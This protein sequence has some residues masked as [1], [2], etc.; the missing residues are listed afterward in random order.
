MTKQISP[1]RGMAV[2]IEGTSEGIA[3]KV[4]TTSSG[5]LG[6]ELVRP[7]Q[8]PFQVGDAVR[9]VYWEKGP[10]VCRWNG[11]II[12]VG[13]PQ[14]RHLILS[15]LDQ[16]VE[17]RTFPRFEAAIPFTFTVVDSANATL[18]G[19]SAA[20]ETQNIGVGGLLFDARH[21]L[22]VGDKLALTLKLSASQQADTLGWVVRSTKVK[23]TQYV[24]GTMVKLVHSVAVEFLQWKRDSQLKLLKFL[25]QSA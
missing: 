5:Q 3:A 9:I 24:G 2:L 1:K 12:N 20:G 21:P 13:G 8:E 11:K 7:A 14:D 25:L 6:L 19:V 18:N 17:Y 10:V 16:T 23:R 15:I 4:L 22:A